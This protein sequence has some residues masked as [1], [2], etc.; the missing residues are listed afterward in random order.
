MSSWRDQNIHLMAKRGGRSIRFLKDGQRRKM[1]TK[2][3]SH[4]ALA[5]ITKKQKESRIAKVE[6]VRVKRST[7]QAWDETKIPYPTADANM[8]QLKSPQMISRDKRANYYKIDRKDISNGKRYEG[9]TVSYKQIW[10]YVQDAMIKKHCV[11]CGKIMLFTR[12]YKLCKRQWSLDRID[13]RYPH[14]EKNTEKCRCLG[15]NEFRGA[16]ERF[17]EPDETV[18]YQLVLEACQYCPSRLGHTRSVHNKML[19]IT[20]RESVNLPKTELVKTSSRRFS[21]MV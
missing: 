7:S 17:L 2:G 13:N 3:S 6:K 1:R 18:S 14:T 5:K 15:C 21:I 4:K 10:K 16:K 9:K 19:K 11:D 12:Y 20:G 8:M